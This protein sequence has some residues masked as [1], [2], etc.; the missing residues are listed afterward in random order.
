VKRFYGWYMVLALALSTT[1]AYGVLYYSFAVFVKPMELELGW[2]RAQTSLAFS[3]ALV[4]AGLIAPFLGRVVD[5]QGARL[6]TSLGATLA[7]MTVFLW[8]QVSSLPM[9]YLT[10]ALLG[11]TMT[12]TFY[13]PAFTV[14]AVWFR[15]G[16]SKA[17]LMITLIAGL[18]STIFVP[19]STFLLEH[20]GWRNSIAVLAGIQLLIAPMLWLVLRRHPHDL[21]LEPDGLIR[22]PQTEVPVVLPLE[23]VHFWRSS[24][25]WSLALGF[26]LARMAVSILAPHLVPLLRER[27]FSSVFAA[28]IAGLVGV[29]Q[30]GGRLI[31]VPMTNRVTLTFLTAVTFA[32]HGLGILLLTSSSEIGVW[33]F[34]ILYGS[35]N[36]AITIARAALTAEL[37]PT[38][39]Y[40]QVSGAISLVVALSGSL[41]P[42]LAGL[43]H[44]KTGNYQSTL[45]VLVALLIISSLTVLNAREKIKS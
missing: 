19:L 2:N 44:Q 31:F 20:L 10:W 21:N 30:L 34:V 1:V 43:L 15:A 39:V 35:T 22:A 9:L 17:I 8:S 14:V 5:K 41:A 7:A 4:V 25:F 26:A 11:F 38:R 13:D 12:A 6:V 16:R 36:G 18:A 42:F 33:G 32:L 24:I 28:T 40:G 37:F 3:L 27:G 29:L 45:W 23:A